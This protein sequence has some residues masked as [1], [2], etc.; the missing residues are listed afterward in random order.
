[1]PSAGATISPSPCGTERT[2][3]R[4]N[5]ATHM[6]IPAIGQASVSHAIQA[7]NKVITAA[8]RMNFRPSGWTLGQRHFTP[9]G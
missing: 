1:M 8:I 3:S 9:V 7:K 4:K 6:V 2:G 5:A